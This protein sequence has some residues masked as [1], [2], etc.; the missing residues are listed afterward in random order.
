MPRGGARRGAGRKPGIPNVVTQDHRDQVD[1][2]FRATFNGENVPKDKQGAAF[3]AMRMLIRRGLQNDTAAIIHL[4]ERTMGR[5]KYTVEHEGNHDKP[6]EHRVYE[7]V[8]DDGLPAIP[9]LP[10]AAAEAVA[11]NGNKAP[12]PA[13]PAARRR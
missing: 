12:V 11:G 8:L 3:H 9:P 2:A 1:L 4:C 10:A 6:L 7:A 13:A 5:L